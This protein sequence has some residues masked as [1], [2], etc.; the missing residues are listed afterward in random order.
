MKK[1]S[2]APCLH[3]I[4]NKASALH[5]KGRSLAAAARKGAGSCNSLGTAASGVNPGIFDHLCTACFNHRAC[6]RTLQSQQL[7]GKPHWCCANAVAIP[8]CSKAAKVGLSPVAFISL[9]LP[10]IF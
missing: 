8:P 9:S 3:N 7:P 5:P 4:A 2:S 6:T 10:A 1:S